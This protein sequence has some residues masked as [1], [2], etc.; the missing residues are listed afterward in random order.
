MTMSTKKAQ[1]V[2]SLDSLLELVR[3]DL[4]DEG[5]GSATRD[6]YPARFVLFDT[7]DDSKK[8]VQRIINEFHFPVYN[9]D[10]WMDSS[11]SFAD[12][13]L[14]RSELVGGI[15]R[16]VRES[17]ES[18]IVTPFSELARFY[19]NTH[20][21]EFDSTLATIKDIE[22]VHPG[23]HQR[24]Y[25][26]II[27]LEEKMMAFHE[28]PNIVIWQLMRGGYAEAE[29]KPDG[30]NVDDAG[31]G[32]KAKNYRLTL[33][34]G[35][36]YG[37]ANLESRFHVV[38]SVREWLQFWKHYKDSADPDGQLLCTS[39]SI[40]ANSGNAR[41]DNAFSYTICR[42]VKEF[43][44][45]GL[46]F[47][48]SGIPFCDDS[49]EYWQRLAAGID[50]SEQTSFAQYAE[51]LLEVKPTIDDDGFL[52]AWFSCANSADVAFRRWVLCQYYQL[53][54]DGY[55]ASALKSVSAY[56]DNCLC[57]TIAF[58]PFS[59]E[60][61][62]VRTQ[63]L[64]LLKDRG[65]SLGDDDASHLVERIC[66]FAAKYG[67]SAALA[68]VSRLTWREQ[69]LVLQWVA[70][71]L[72][73]LEEAGPVFPD[74]VAYLGQTSI[75][76]ELDRHADWVP[77]YIGAYKRARVLAA[78]YYG[79]EIDGE[80][81]KRIT[82]EVEAVISE[83]N[84]STVRFSEWYDRFN[85]V[86][87]FLHGHNEIDSLFWI[88]GLG[89]DWIPFVAN[90]VKGW[91]SKGF[92]LNEVHIAMAQLPSVT[93][94]NKKELQRLSDSIADNKVGD[95]D[96]MAH[97]HKATE[98]PKLMEEMAVVRQA[99]EKA[100]AKHAG[101]K[102]AIVSDHGL[103][104]MSQFYPGLG[105][106][107]FDDD[108][109]GRTARSV[110]VPA[111]KN[112]EAYKVLPDGVTVCALRHASLL[113]KVPKGEGAHGGLTPEECLVPI[114]IVSPSKKGSSWQA[115]LL[116]HADIG[117]N[118]VVR[119][120]VKGLTSG[121]M[122]KLIY[123]GKQYAVSRQADVYTSDNLNLDQACRKVVVS[124]DGDEQPLDI[125]FTLGVEED[126]LF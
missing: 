26:P 118:P 7:F 121:A 42:N 93:S 39:P 76:D 50:I 57:H 45:D 61:D 79:Q 30:Q 6:R 102:I 114:F 91:E 62:N 108:Y 99:I 24:I 97:E 65:V 122:P 32:E 113:G 55:L 60:G 13:L 53:H 5:V 51:Q 63:C 74:L 103:T 14:S 70:K 19:D 17:G 22:S 112:D 124:I 31:Q 46:H 125:D 49:L 29:A 87:N 9:A 21:K 10:K 25:I 106:Q 4:G 72:V 56:D 94:V 85:A 126:D 28:S 12:V 90:V 81:R 89:I 78:S 18:F 86:S 2:S 69:F 64:N 104:Y 98:M 101:K 111:P 23:S 43:L 48:T 123:N 52:K 27:G 33:T 11:P 37:V 80:R 41:P 107:N 40:F 119:F 34:N 88:D 77:E 83:R 54:S 117:N 58:L 100:L 59:A 96:H 110:K 8:F 105:L 47:G 16:C 73:S 116:S 35:S 92:Y 82:E 71:G 67:E 36:T 115:V 66:D 75:S 84:A 3:S 15:R 120:K 109:H 1:I 44:S 38:N 20:F 68:H 95:L